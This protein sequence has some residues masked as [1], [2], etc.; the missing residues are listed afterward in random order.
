MSTQESKQKEKNRAST[1]FTNFSR[2]GGK[3][4]SGTPLGTS[5]LPK[6]ARTNSPP[7]AGK[8]LP[9]PPLA[10]SRGSHFRWLGTEVNVKRILPKSNIET[11]LTATESSAQAATDPIIRTADSSAPG[12]GQ[13]RNPF[14]EQ[15]GTAVS[16]SRKLIKPSSSKHPQDNEGKS[17]KRRFEQESKGLSAWVNSEMKNRR[18]KVQVFPSTHNQTPP[19]V[20]QD[21]STSGKG[22][23][24]KRDSAGSRHT[25]RAESEAGDSE[26]GDE[27][28]SPA[29]IRSMRDKVAESIARDMVEKAAKRK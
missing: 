21:R 15:M 19:A 9:Y 1:S 12:A 28:F 14:K 25:G 4:T 18:R 7:R 26:D 22:K 23:E 17:N 10:E 8:H 6:P 27:S 11:D 5:K 20:T 3:G 2:R 24:S 16:T 13:R 29:K